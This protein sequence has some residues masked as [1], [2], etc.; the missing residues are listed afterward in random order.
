[1][2]KVDFKSYT[3]LQMSY[4]YHVLT[5]CLLVIPLVSGIIQRNKRFDFWLV[6]LRIL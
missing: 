3:V 1:L 5:Y 6:Q 2:V 4:S